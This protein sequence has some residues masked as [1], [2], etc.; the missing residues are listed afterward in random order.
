MDVSDWGA[1]AS[2][3]AAATAAA[4][5]WR[6]VA[7]SVRRSL[8]ELHA[9]GLRN[10]QTG[11]LEVTVTNTGGGVAKGTVVIAMSGTESAGGHLGDGFVAPGEAFRVRT[12]LDVPT[13]DP[14]VPI[15]VYCLDGENVLRAWASHGQKKVYRSP[16]SRRKRYPGHE[17]TFRDLYPNA[18][19]TELPQHGIHVERLPRG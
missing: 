15:V 14:D 5:A 1:L 16:L 10:G 2:A 3:V 17:R 4:A 9:Q 6:S 7:L 8:P 18:R 11:K 12:N 19:V 13:D